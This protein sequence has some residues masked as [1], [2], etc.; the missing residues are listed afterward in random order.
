[1]VVLTIEFGGRM[2]SNNWVRNLITEPR[3][4]IAGNT[5]HGTRRPERINLEA[6]RG[7]KKSEKEAMYANRDRSADCPFVV[8]FAR[9]HSPDG[10]DADTIRGKISSTEE[11][12]AEMRVSSEIG[13]SEVVQK[14]ED[15]KGL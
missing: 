10:G 3:K 12:S 2:D 6:L 5:S 15:G 13:A 4:S 9:E 1:M 8:S 7:S 11:C 14:L